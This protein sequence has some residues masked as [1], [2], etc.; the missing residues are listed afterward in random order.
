MTG[1]CLL[2]SYRPTNATVSEALHSEYIEVPLA[3][4]ETYD[5]NVLVR[6]L[7]TGMRMINGGSRQI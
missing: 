2:L 4:E 3:R 6:S 7:S 1:Y 5:E